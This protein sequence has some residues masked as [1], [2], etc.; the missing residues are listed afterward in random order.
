M[1][2]NLSDQTIRASHVD[3]PAHVAQR[4]FVDETVA[5]NLETGRYHGLNSTASRMLSA[6][7]EG[8]TVEATARRL[9]PELEQPYERVERDLVDLCRALEQRGL[10][11]IRNGDDE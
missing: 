6:L 11:T 5:L 8:A 4:E 2:A 7:A 10:I 3:V 1:G 9:A